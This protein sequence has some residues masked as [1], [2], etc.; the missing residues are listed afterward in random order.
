M[1]KEN[2]L[3]IKS[4]T[5]EVCNGCAFDQGF[6]TIKGSPDPCG[7]CGTDIFIPRADTKAE[8]FDVTRP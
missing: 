5:P 2:F 4:P 6:D 8:V 1:A 7:V 3:R